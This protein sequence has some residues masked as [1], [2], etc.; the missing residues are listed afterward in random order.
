MHEAYRLIDVHGSPINGA[1]R[2]ANKEL[3]GVSIRMKHPRARLSRSADRGLPFS[4]LGEFL[5][6]LT[7][8][9]DPEFIAAYIPKYRDEVGPSGRINGAYGPRLFSAYGL[10]QI[11]AVV[12]LLH[13]KPDTR[14]AV[15]QLYAGTDLRTDEEVP[16]TTTLQFFIRENQL[17]LMASLRSNDAYFG[18]PHDIFFFTMV[19]EMIA[20]RMKLKLGEY[21][22]MVGSFH[23][24]GKHQERAARYRKEGHQ[25]LF[26]MPPMPSGNPFETV[27]Q[28]L[29]IEERIRA[30]KGAEAISALPPYWADLMR[31][32]EAHF[33]KD[34]EAMDTLKAQLN[35][36]NYAVYIDDLQD[37]R[38]A[39]ANREA[40]EKE[41][42]A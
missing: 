34:P 13:R 4:A 24:Y 38:T 11:E 37:R 1:T 27:S 25:S 31:L 22:Q 28:L 39:Q 21:R 20:T 32:V 36:V 17:H 14:R 33:T 12:E 8:D 29:A 18:L 41:K 19:Q 10:D 30:G 9:D 15:I 3:I 7:K 2:G 40:N 35:N 42:G 23:L 5:W 26:Q 16:C 6:Y